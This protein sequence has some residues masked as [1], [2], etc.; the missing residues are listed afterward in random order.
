MAS[1]QIMVWDMAKGDLRDCTIFTI[2]KTKRSKQRVHGQ[3]FFSFF[4][5]SNVWSR[6]VS[7]HPQED[8]AKFGYWKKVEKC[9]IPLTCWN[10]LFKYGHFRKKNPHNVVTHYDGH[11]PPLPPLKVLCIICT[12]IVFFWVTTSMQ[13]FIA[14]KKE[15][16]LSSWVTKLTMCIIITSMMICLIQFGRE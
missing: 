7:D 9:R 5:P 3:W 15:R 16:T 2:Y 10:L 1:I 8:L 6:W 14:P 12:S 4:F 13:K 11:I